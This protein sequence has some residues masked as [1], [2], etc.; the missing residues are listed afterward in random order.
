MVIAYTR[1]PEPERKP[2]QPVINSGTGRSGPANNR[3]DG[4]WER[5]LDWGD[6]TM[7]RAANAVEDKVRDTGRGGL[8]FAATVADTVLPN[9]ATP[10]ILGAVEGGVGLAMTPISFASRGTAKVAGWL[11]LDGVESKMNGVN[12]LTTSLSRVDLHAFGN[13]DGLK[14]NWIELYKDWLFERKRP[15]L[16]TWDKAPD[17]GADRVTITDP[18]YTSDLASRQNQKDALAKF[19]SEHP[20]PQENDTSTKNFTY[21]GKGTAEGGNYTALELFLGSYSTKVT[22]KKDAATGKLY[23][24]YEVTNELHWESG[25]R[26]PAVAQKVGLPKH[27]MPDAKRGE[28]IGLGGD[29]EQRFVWR[30][31]LDGSMAQADASRYPV[32][33][34]PALPKNPTPDQNLALQRILTQDP[35]MTPER[36]AHDRNMAALSGAAYKSEGAPPNYERVHNYEDKKSGFAATLFRDTRTNTYVLAFRGSD[37]ALVRDYAKANVPQGVGLNTRQYDEA[38]ALSR[39]LKRQYGNQLTDITGHS[40]GGGLAAAGS[41]ATNTRATTFNASGVH[42]NTAARNGLKWD[43]HNITNYFV[44]GEVLS[45]LEEAPPF[46]RALGRQITI[47]SLGR[48]N[49]AEPYSKRDPVAEHGIDYVLRGMLV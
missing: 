3:H 27:L 26:T 40:L 43:E 34:G 4:W 47:M 21:T 14:G 45:T 28:G 46:P 24:E 2:P 25:T 44:E 10:K 39:Q 36:L 18:L 19:M 30:Q 7:H 37:G 8:Q 32:S 42:P 22:C 13:Q 6:R 16:G 23:L 17:T 33:N 48:D 31:E 38:A 15:T 35:S 41:M 29:F 1:L 9:E 12:T 49:V 5:G 11:G 20:V